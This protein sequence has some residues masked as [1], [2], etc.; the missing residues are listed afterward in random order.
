ML[1]WRAEPPRRRA[2]QCTRRAH[3]RCLLGQS[4][5]AARAAGAC[6]R[7]TGLPPS[8]PPV[9]RAHAHAA[10]WVAGRGGAP[11]TVPGGPEGGRQ[12]SQRWRA[13]SPRNARAAVHASDTTGAGGAG[14]AR[15]RRVCRRPRGGW[16]IASSSLAR[17]PQSLRVIVRQG[18][19]RPAAPRGVRDAAR[20]TV[21]PPHLTCAFQDS[22]HPGVSSLPACRDLPVLDGGFSQASKERSMCGRHHRVGCQILS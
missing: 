13:R 7:A 4:P 15:R 19:Q 3:H 12:R 16:T 22:P 6:Q 21:N 5:V 8:R 11:A 18:S 2:Q 14:P 20:R 17:G 9:P 10:A 1:R